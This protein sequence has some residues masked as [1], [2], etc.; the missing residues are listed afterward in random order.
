[1]SLGPG[2]L[3]A[4]TPAGWAA[5]ALAD[6][7]AFL[8]DHA[9]CERKAAALCL[10]FVAKYLEHP[11][12][13]EPMISVAREELEHFQQVFRILTRRGLSP[14]KDEKDPYVKG[15]QAVMRHTEDGRLLD[16]LVV[17]A[18]IEARSCERLELV[19]EAL[20]DPELKDFYATLARVEAGHY[21][22]FLKIAERFFDKETVAVA[23]DR[24][25]TAE[26]AVMLATPWRAAVH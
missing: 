16:R 15:L 23:V 9:A 11:F 20:V 5:V 1:M 2:P 10:S 3:K 25:A 4:A 22:V 12:V 26:A 14:G 6:F 18:L 24:L 19:A 13:V 8:R 17:S 21:K 7:D